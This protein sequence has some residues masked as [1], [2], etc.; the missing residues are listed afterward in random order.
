MFG[1][2]M[3]LPRNAI[4]IKDGMVEQSQFSDYAPARITD[5]PRIDIHFVPSE[6]APTGLGEP[7]VPPIA[8]AIA[9]A[10]AA[11]SGKRLR[12]LPFE[13]TV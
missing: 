1:L 3:T 13:L 6:D 8:P 4:T 2:S 12:K 5:T 9:N 7:G 11:L 10:V